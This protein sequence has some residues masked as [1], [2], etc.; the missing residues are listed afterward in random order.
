MVEYTQNADAD[1]WGVN[2]YIYTYAIISPNIKVSNPFHNFGAPFVRL[3]ALYGASSALGEE[4]FGA[5]E[6]CRWIN[7]KVMLYLIKVEV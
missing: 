4:P 1:S 3:S 5:S 2:I 7:T 6:A